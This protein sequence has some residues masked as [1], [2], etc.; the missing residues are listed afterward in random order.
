MHGIERNIV[1][2]KAGRKDSDG[3]EPMD[4]QDEGKGSE[5]ISREAKILTGGRLIL[6]L[7]INEASKILLRDVM[8]RKD[9]LLFGGF[10]VSKI[11]LPETKILTL[12]TYRQE[13]L[14]RWLS[15]AK[16]IIV[17]GLKGDHQINMQC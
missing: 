10:L 14:W 11:R 1:K 7:D 6:D 15:K 17:Q 16:D 13:A 5:K 4:K 3:A 8:T 2:G 12:K 9:L